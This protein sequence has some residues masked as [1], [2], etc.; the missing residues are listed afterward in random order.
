[1]PFATNESELVYSLRRRRDSARY[2]ITPKETKQPTL[3]PPVF[4]FF[5][6]LTTQKVG[7]FK[8]PP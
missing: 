5:S 3:G 6:R 1:M 8:L 2:A 4:H 7:I